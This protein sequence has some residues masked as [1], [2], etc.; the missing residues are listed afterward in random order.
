MESAHTA[1]HG[2]RP[3]VFGEVLFDCFPDGSQVLG[4]APFNVAWHLQGFGL[5]PQFVSRIGADSTGQRVRDAMSDWQMNLE[6]VQVDTEHP[7]GSVRVEFTGGE[8]TYEIVDAQA[9]DYIEFPEFGE[10]PAG[11]LYHGTLALRHRRSRDALL[12]LRAAHGLPVFVDLNLR[13]PWWSEAVVSELLPGTCCLKL[14]QD[15]LHR[16]LAL[17]C[18]AGCADPQALMDR[19]GWQQLIVTRGAHGAIVYAAESPAP[20]EVAP[21]ETIEVVDTVGAGDAFS[22]VMILGLVHSWPLRQTLERAQAFAGEVCKR[23]GATIKDPRLYTN[24]LAV[25]EPQNAS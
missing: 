16:L 24:L 3:I 11:V 19:F 5:S 15:E 8:P 18:C 4:G 25:W 12:K 7:T 6:Q 22:A 20:L 17:R 14:N 13:D 9:Y 2:Q 23:Q 1:T 10:A 21:S